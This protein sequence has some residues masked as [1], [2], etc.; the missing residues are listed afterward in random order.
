M[1]TEEAIWDAVWAHGEGDPP[2]V[3]VHIEVEGAVEPNVAEELIGP[4][5]DPIRVPPRGATD[6]RLVVSRIRD[7][8]PIPRDQF[9]QLAGVAGD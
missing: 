4:D 2:V 6:K 9:N 3:T 8:R 5:G 7:I 1:E